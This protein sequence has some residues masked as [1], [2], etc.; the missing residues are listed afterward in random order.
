MA[1]RLAIGTVSTAVLTLSTAVFAQQP[2][3]GTASI[4]DFSGIWSH[5]TILDVEP[6]L[7]GPGPVRNL[8]RITVEIARTLAPYN[9]PNTGAATVGPNGVSNPSMPVG[10]FTN[11]I[12]KPEAAEVVKQHGELS[13]K[14][15]TYPTPTN[16]CWP[17]GVPFVFWNKGMQMLQ[18]K[19]KVTI[20]YANDR[21]VRHV[22][23]DRTHP[24]HVTPSWTGDS[25]GHYEGDTLVIDTVGI[26]V[27]PFAMVD[28]YGTPYTEALHVV[29]R[30]RLLDYE[31]ANESEDRG[32][33]ENFRMQVSDTGL[34]RDLNYKGPGLLL[35]Y[36]VEDP[37]VFTTPWSARITYRRPLGRWPEFVCAESTQDYVGRPLDL[38][39]ADKPDF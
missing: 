15:I 28:E 5:L 12:L 27:G 4:P 6:P 32:E 3:Q 9:N 16:Q 20:L 18:Q 2:S 34:A 39:H 26:K 14:F 19:D 33:K 13:K 22:Y 25:V 36:T 23:M 35:E 10:D 7:S 8:S 1:C 31:S 24:E 30:Y 38:P 17:S 37:G 11:P 21:S 29:E